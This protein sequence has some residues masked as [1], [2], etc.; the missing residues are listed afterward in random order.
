LRKF[1][2]KKRLLPRPPEM[3]RHRLPK[4]RLLLKRP[5]RHLLLPL[6]PPSQQPL[7]VQN[8]VPLKILW[9]RFARVAPS[10]LP[11]PQQRPQPLPRLRQQNPLLVPPAHGL[12]FKIC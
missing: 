12:P 7:L 6:R 8:R 11:L 2:L 1:A 3:L 5:H 10:L 9:P 4:L